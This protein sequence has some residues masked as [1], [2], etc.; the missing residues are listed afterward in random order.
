MAKPKKAMR[1]QVGTR[2]QV[3]L[4][5]H[6]HLRER[7][8]KA[9]KDS[10]RSLNAEI[11]ERLEQSFQTEERFG[12]P[13][14]V[15]LAESI[16]T[17]MS[18]TGQRAAFYETSEIMSAS[19]WLNMPFPYDQAKEAANA[20]LERFRPPGKIVVPKRSWGEVLGHHRSKDDPKEAAR[21]AK[22]FEQIGR[23]LAYGGEEAIGEALAAQ[24]RAEKKMKE[25]GK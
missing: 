6:E 19:R 25:T 7:V 4:R 8:E 13:G 3:G 2:A 17:L 20:I 5:I 22:I 16:T 21:M 1:A 10:G 11:L 9:A 23:L 12:G 14:L 24:E 15:D 18:I